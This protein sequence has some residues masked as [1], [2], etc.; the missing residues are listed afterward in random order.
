[1][2]G[3]RGRQEELDRL[4]LEEAG[5]RCRECSG[6][7]LRDYY[8]VAVKVRLIPPPSFL[9]SLQV[10]QRSSYKPPA[11]VA[12]ELALDALQLDTVSLGA[13]R[14][15]EMEEVAVRVRSEFHTK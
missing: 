3:C 10:P 13:P 9:V 12:Q 7:S 14:Q 4:A 8:R 5:L 2:A 11:V 15:V 1:M 6:S